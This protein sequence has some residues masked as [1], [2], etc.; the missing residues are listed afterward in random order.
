MKRIYLMTLV[1]SIL[2]VSLGSCDLKR[3]P[4]DAIPTDESLQT[5]VDLSRWETGATVAL[6]SMQQDLLSLIHI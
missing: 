2:G 4:T 6:R 1:A 3:T 5:V